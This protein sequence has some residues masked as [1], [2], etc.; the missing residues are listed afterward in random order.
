MFPSQISIPH[1]E[2]IKLIGELQNF[3]LMTT[4]LAFIQPMA[5]L[6]SL[7][8][9]AILPKMPVLNINLLE[10]LSANPSALLETIRTAIKNRVNIPF[11]EFPFYLTLSIPDFEAVQVLSNLTRYYFNMLVG[12]V[13]DLI[14]S[15]TDYLDIAGMIALPTLPTF[16]EVLS[17]AKTKLGIPSPLI[18]NISIPEFE[19]QEA[20]GI[21]MNMAIT[22]AMDAIMSFCTNAL[23]SFLTFTFPT[24]CITV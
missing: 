6:L 19:L 8:L 24:L 20:V 13:E 7:S 14:G 11:V 5:D 21:Y 9:D 1:L 17:L 12:F 23:S 15:V 10:L 2:A 3:Q 22:A 18:P 16:A 4:F